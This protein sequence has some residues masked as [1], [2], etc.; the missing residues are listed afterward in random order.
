MGRPGTAF[1]LACNNPLLPARSNLQGAPSYFFPAQFTKTAGQRV[2]G[3]SGDYGLDVRLDGTSSKTILSAPAEVE[4]A[5]L[6]AHA[7]TPIEELESDTNQ[8]GVLDVGDL[9]RLYSPPGL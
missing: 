1:G 7:L 3:R 2:L 6:G 8:D 4:S 5:I 9:V